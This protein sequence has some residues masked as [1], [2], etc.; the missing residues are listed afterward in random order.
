MALGT[1]FWAIGFTYAGALRGTGDTRWPMW[2]NSANI[3]ISVLLAAFVGIALQ[4]N[5]TWVWAA[6]IATSPIAPV[7]AVR[8][9]RHVAARLAADHEKS[10]APA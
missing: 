6:F 10:L 2:V 1:P 5:L 9:F 3:W 7:L 4:A 8:R